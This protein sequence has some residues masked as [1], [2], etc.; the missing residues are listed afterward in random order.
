MEIETPIV[1]QPVKKNKGGRPRKNLSASAAPAAPILDPVAA[2]STPEGQAL[3]ARIVSELMEKRAD[4]GT[5][6]QPDDMRVARALA[7][8]IGEMNDQGSNVKKVPAE[9]ME[10]RREARERMETLILDA[11]ANDEVPEY[12]LT[13][14]VYLDE[15]LV[16]ATY[17]DSAHI[18][19]RTKIAWPNVPNEHMAP[20]NEA[21]RGISRSFMRS[22]GGATLTAQ[23][24]SGLLK[25]REGGLSV[26]HKEATEKSAPE[27][28]KPRGTDLRI[29]GR[30]QPGEII[31]TQVL[32]SVAQPARQLA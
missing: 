25:T 30:H 9:E 31:E 5:Q 15:V 27:V 4:A 3:M 29:I 22:I 21:A 13:G 18:R 1:D 32:G 24:T 23:P 11:R 16:A 20:T 26:L 2:L 17:I 6:S 8:A 7:V 28:G 14:A 12:E 10:K 19:R